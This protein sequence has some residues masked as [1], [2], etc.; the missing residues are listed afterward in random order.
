MDKGQTRYYRGNRAM[1]PPPSAAGCGAAHRQLLVC[2]SR[3][4]SPPKAQGQGSTAACS[5][6]RGTRVGTQALRGHCHC[7]LR[8]RRM[9]AGEGSAL[10]LG[11]SPAS[12]PV[13]VPAFP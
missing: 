10:L 2:L 9:E 3:G 8:T 1:P 13:P 11:T 4:L 5:I 6:G 12:V 7:A